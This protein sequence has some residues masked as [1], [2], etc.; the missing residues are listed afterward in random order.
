M[1]MKTSLVELPS[2]PSAMESQMSA[3]SQHITHIASA[4]YEGFFFN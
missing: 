1:E 2:I 3:Q 4:H